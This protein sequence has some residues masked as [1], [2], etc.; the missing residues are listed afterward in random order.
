MTQPLDSQLGF[1]FLAEL[2][3]LDLAPPKRAARAPKAAAKSATA[4]PTPPQAPTPAAAPT[5][6]L[7]AEAMAQALE[8]HPDYR[9]QRRLVPR[10]DWPGTA[11][12]AVQRILVLDTETTGLDQAREKIIELALLRVDVDTATGLPVGPVQVYDGLED[13]RKP[14]PAEVVKITGIT[15][16]DVQGQ[17]LDE[18]RVAELLQGVDVVIAH[19]AG[20]DRP[21]VESRLPAFAKVAWACSF[22]DIDWK[23]QGRGSAKLESLAQALGLFYDAH[24][25]EMDCHALLAVLAAPL[26]QGTGTALAHLL[27]AARNPSYRLSATNAPFEAK[28]LLKARGY[29]WNADQ[30]VWATRLSDD[31]A[32][33]AEFAWLKEQVYNNRHAA[34]Q[35]ETLDALAKYSARSGVTVHQQL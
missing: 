3:T 15:D 31:A 33:H 16:A 13:P 2:P 25:A 26:P 23:A 8:A 7:D 34:V 4:K 20:F 29:R 12:G 28:D 9:V 14:I 24:R 6:T 21:F 18:A 11:Q 17:A 35:I 10:L 1:A 22:A 27:Q 5:A 32:L 30:R 19:N